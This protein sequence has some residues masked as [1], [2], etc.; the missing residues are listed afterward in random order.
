MINRIVAFCFL[1]ISS[2]YASVPT[3]TI[4]VHGSQNMT[5]LLPSNIWYCKKGLHHISDLPDDSCFVKDAILL[6]QADCNFFSVEHYYTFGWS[7]KISFTLR[8]IAGQ[9]LFND[10]QKLLEKYKADY[11]IYP[12]IRFVT[13]SHGGNVVLNMLNLFPV[14]NDGIVNLEVVM[15]ACPVQKVTEELIEHT[16]ITRSYIM[17][18][19]FDLIQLLDFYKYKD[20]YYFPNRCFNTNKANCTQ[21]LVK[22]NGHRLSHTD[23]AHSFVRHIPEVIKATKNK[24]GH[25]VYDVHDPSFLFYNGFNISSAMQANRLK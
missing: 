3:V 20:R 25:L 16:A 8:E 18:S 10:L 23:L 15:L 5:K 6:Q 24:F 4:F 1:F 19:T 2:V 13:H 22:V 12:K 7:G 17:Y 14:V 11:K 21:I 9:E